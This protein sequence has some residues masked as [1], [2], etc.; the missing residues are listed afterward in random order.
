MGNCKGRQNERQ[1][2][3]QLLRQETHPGSPACLAIAKALR[4]ESLANIPV[5]IGERRTI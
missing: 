4:H 3:N 5:R 2:K 1:Q